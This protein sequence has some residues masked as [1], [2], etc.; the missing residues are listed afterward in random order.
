MQILS[1]RLILIVLLIG[2][3]APPLCRA[4]LPSVRLLVS[5]PTPFVGEELILTLEIRT[6]LRPPGAI[7]PVWP[8][9]DHC[10]VTE[11]PQ[12]PPRL[13]EEGP[14]ALIQTVRRAVRPFRPGPLPLSGAG[15][16]I[17]DRFWP[18]PALELRVDQLPTQGRPDGFA[19]A[20]GRI[21]M[22]LEEAGRGDREIRLTLKG[23]APLANFPAPRADP[24]AGERL[25]LLND[26]TSGATDGERI[27]TLRYLYLPGDADRGRLTFRLPVFDPKSRRYIVL[28]S[29]IRHLPSRPRIPLLPAIGLSAAI[30]FL[31]L[32][33]RNRPPRSLKVALERALG[34]ETTGLSRRQIVERLRGRGA[35]DRLLGDLADLWDE[36]DRA[37]F[38]PSAPPATDTPP[39][40]PT[41]LR[42]LHRLARRNLLPRR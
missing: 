11:L 22:E 31:V 18:A 8:D 15:M 19:G 35:N 37:R 41:V 16:K 17:G 34:G 26:A 21:S 23:D 9:L 20:I 10:A 27:R 40:R 25:I 24:G 13:D 3:S 6:S 7:T 30:L 42:Q 39:L 12:T 38:A 33:L 14:L 32:L 1:T 29:G 2:L 5:N 36:E 4:D 28:E